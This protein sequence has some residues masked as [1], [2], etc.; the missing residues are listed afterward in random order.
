MA[1]FVRKYGIPFIKNLVSIMQIDF[2]SQ[3][4]YF[5]RFFIE[6]RGLSA[7]LDN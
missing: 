2:A 7:I 6:M 5:L 3:H 1:N 4:L